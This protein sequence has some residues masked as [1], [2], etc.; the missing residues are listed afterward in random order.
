M[1]C[2][3]LKDYIKRHRNATVALKSFGAI[4][5]FAQSKVD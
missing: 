2:Y 5:C 1:C 3:L 4:I